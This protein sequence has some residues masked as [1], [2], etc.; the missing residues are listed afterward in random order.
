MVFSESQFHTNVAERALLLP[1]FSC[2]CF[3]KK[4]QIMVNA[5][6]HIHELREPTF[7]MNGGMEIHGNRVR[8][9]ITKFFYRDS[10]LCFHILLQVDGGE[11]VFFREFTDYAEYKKAFS[12]LQQ[13]R[14]NNIIINAPKKNLATN[15]IV[16]KVA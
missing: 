10:H 5:V 9:L 12:D 13:A 1:V 3:D 6:R 8:D 7:G 15:S 16:A 4:N 14:L 11:T 2:R